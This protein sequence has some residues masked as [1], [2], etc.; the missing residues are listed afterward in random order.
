MVHMSEALRLG[1]SCRR[2][3]LRLRLELFIG[4]VI[5]VVVSQSFHFHF[6]DDSLV[7]AGEKA[8]TEKKGVGNPSFQHNS[9]FDYEFDE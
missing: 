5:D 3:G 6:H 9:L 1:W 7:C 2:L 8:E 4:H